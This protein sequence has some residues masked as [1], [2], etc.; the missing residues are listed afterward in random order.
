MGTS[1]LPVWP[2]PGAPRWTRGNG[3]RAW[4]RKNS[5]SYARLSA[6][7]GIVYSSMKLGSLNEIHRTKLIEGRYIS[8]RCFCGVVEL[9]IPILAPSPAVQ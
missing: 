5:G 1:R 4:S 2:N 3:T 6:S 9:Q 8:G 7:D